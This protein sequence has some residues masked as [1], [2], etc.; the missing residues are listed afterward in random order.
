MT[1][2]YR[3]LCTTRH[4]TVSWDHDQLAFSLRAKYVL[5]HKKEVCY[6]CTNLFDIESVKR[7]R[8]TPDPHLLLGHV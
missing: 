2:K 6:D 4:M 8:R 3:W 1:L 5:K 7:E